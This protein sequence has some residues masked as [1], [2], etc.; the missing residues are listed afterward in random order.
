MSY[1]YI[2]YTAFPPL[3]STYFCHVPQKSPPPPFKKNTHTGTVKR[4]KHDGCRSTTLWR[5]VIQ[6]SQRGRWFV[7]GSHHKRIMYDYILLMAEILHRLIDS[8]SRYFQGFIHP[9]WCRISAINS[10]IV[11][12][13]IYMFDMNTGMII[14]VMVIYI[15]YGYYGMF[16]FF[17]RCI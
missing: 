15:Y 1:I 10:M 9:R 16:M 13:G 4:P 14:Y 3:K 12:D 11:F 6:R 8:L 7:F 5:I 17:R 2:I